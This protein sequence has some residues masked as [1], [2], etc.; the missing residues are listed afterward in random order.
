M[1]QIVDKVMELPER[2][3]FQILSPIVRGRK[4]EYRKE[5][6]DLVKQGYARVRIDGIIYDLSEQIKLDKNKKHNIEVVVDRLV[7]KEDIK[8]RLSDSL[9]VAGNLSGGLI[10]IDVID[11]EELSFS[12]NY[13]CPEHGVSIEELVAENV[14]VQQSLRRLSYLHRSRNFQKDRCRPDFT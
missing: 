2:T 5:L 3:K 8:S 14:L 6:E 1:D 12:Q 10:L 13:A 11:G 4:G 9:E 7:M